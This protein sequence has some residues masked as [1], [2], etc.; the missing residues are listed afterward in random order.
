MGMTHIKIMN[1]SLGTI[2]KYVDLK[3]M[4]YKCNASI[5]FNRQYL[6]QHIT[7]SYANIRIPNTSLAHKYTQRKIPTIR[8]T[9]E[10][11]YL[12]AKKQ[13]LNIQIYHLHISPYHYK[14]HNGDDAHHNYEC[15]SRPHPQVCRH[16][17]KVIQV[18]WKHLFQQT[19]L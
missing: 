15:Q 13:Q 10:I 9:D 12:H 2:Q 6:K 5:Y 3:R 8:I 11:R 7:P 4:L 18:H 17:E 1:S 19:V 16:K 14:K